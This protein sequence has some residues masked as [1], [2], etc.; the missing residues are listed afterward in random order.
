MPSFADLT[1]RTERLLLRPI[2]ESDAAAMF[3]MYSDPRVTRYLAEPP[4][5]SI[6]R[7]HERIAKGVRA[8]SDGLYI[9]LGLEVTDG[10]A[11]I[12]ECTLFNLVE[13][14]RRAEVGYV[15][16]RDAWGRGYMHEALTA[17]LDYGFSE[18]ALNRVEAD[19]DP[20]NE[21]SAR[22]LE[23]LGFVQEG[24]LRERW[25]VDGEVSDTGFYG[26]LAREWRAL[27][28]L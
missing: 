3:A 14:C 28:R 19:I 12:G 18:M 11:Y 6:D 10:G 9:R 7:A 26:L 15:L 4:W 2:R 1:L 27:R 13:Q 22:I 21:A 17:L 25:I 24:L 20:R 16:A 8:T 5:T 23:R